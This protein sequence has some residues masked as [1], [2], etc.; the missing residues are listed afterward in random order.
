MMTLNGM[1]KL[2]EECGAEWNDRR[3]W[4]ERQNG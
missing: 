3:T 4:K 1:A 2:I